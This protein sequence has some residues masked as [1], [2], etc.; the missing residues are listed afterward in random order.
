MEHPAM[1][2]D[3]SYMQLSAELGAASVY[4]LHRSQALHGT[5]IFAYIGVV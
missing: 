4:L 1:Q 3:P 2:S 5:G